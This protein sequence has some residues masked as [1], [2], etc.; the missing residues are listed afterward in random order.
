[1]SCSLHDRADDPLVLCV[2]MVGGSLDEEEQDNHGDEG[3][4]V[5]RMGKTWTTDGDQQTRQPRTHQHRSFASRIEQREGLRQL[6][7][8]VST[9]S[10]R[11]TMPP[12]DC[13][14]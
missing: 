14:I 2:D 8:R 5:E 7:V 3:C 6:P 4:R 9:A 10:V 12:A 11:A 1:M 13:D